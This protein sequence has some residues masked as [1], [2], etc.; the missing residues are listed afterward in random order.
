MDGIEPRGAQFSRRRRHRCR[1]TVAWLRGLVVAVIALVCQLVMNVSFERQT[2]SK[3]LRSFTW[4]FYRQPLMFLLTVIK[5]VRSGRLAA[6][7]LCLYRSCS[8]S[9][10]QDSPFV[11]DDKVELVGQ[12]EYSWR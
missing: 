12:R 5:R 2:S 9:I 1:P 3:L 11:V 8:F 6:D 10:V 4:Q 7:L